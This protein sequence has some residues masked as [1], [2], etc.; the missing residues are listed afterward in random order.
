VFGGYSGNADPTTLNA[1][2]SFDGTSWTLR[3]AEG[4]VGS[5]SPRGRCAVAW[6][7]TR[8]Q[9]IVFGGNI[10]GTSQALLDETWE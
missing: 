1:L 2:Y 10:G 4:A 6:D 8:N 9:L 5:P 7:F 3:T